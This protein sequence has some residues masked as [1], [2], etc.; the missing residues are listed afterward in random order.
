MRKH[1]NFEQKTV[2]PTIFDC[3][4]DYSTINAHS[5]FLAYTSARYRDVCT[6]SSY[7]M[8]PYIKFVSF[9]FRYGLEYTLPTFTRLETLTTRL[10]QHMF[11]KF[12]LKDHVSVSEA[13]LQYLT[14]QHFICVRTPAAELYITT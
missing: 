8:S 12:T 6:I 1:R 7:S 5:L 11:Y 10:E 3:L 13:T 4:M 9:S 14:F 2:V